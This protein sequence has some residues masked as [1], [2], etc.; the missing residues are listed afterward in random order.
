MS[1]KVSSTDYLTNLGSEATSSCTQKHEQSQRKRKLR[2]HDPPPRHYYPG[3]KKTT[4]EIQ[5]IQPILGESASMRSGIG[6][7]TGYHRRNVSPSH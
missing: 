4:P 1:I 6:P 3:L 5:S 7:E 2:K